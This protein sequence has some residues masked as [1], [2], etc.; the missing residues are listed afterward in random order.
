MKKIVFLT[1]AF[2]LIFNVV[3]N[4]PDV[5]ASN[6]SEY[7]DVEIDGENVRSRKIDI[8]FN[9]QALESDVPP[10]LY[11]SRTL[12][13][14]RFIAEKL[15]AEIEWIQETKE[16]KIKALGK[17]IVLKIDSSDVIINGQ[18]KKLPYD[19]P[20]KLVNNARTMIP[21]RFVM[22][23]LGCDIYWNPE[24][25][26][27]EI[28]I[29][30]QEIV[31]IIIDDSTYLPRITVE[32]T[33]VVVYNAVEIKELNK[34]VI[35]IPCSKLNIKDEEKIDSRML[36]NMDVDKFPVQRIRASQFQID[37]Y[38]TRVVLD[39]DNI[40]DYKIKY[41]DEGNGFE[42]VFINRITDISLEND[43]DEEKIV[44]H[45]SGKAKYSTFILENPNRIVVDL[46]SSYY[47]GDKYKYNL[48][49]DFVDAVRIAQFEPSGDYNKNENIVRI[50]LDI[51]DTAYIPNLVTKN[52]DGNLALYLKENN[53]RS[54][55]YKNEDIEKASLSINTLEKADCEVSY[56][57]NIKSM[58]IRFNKDKINLSN[59]MLS[60][61]DDIVSN[62]TIKED[63][64]DKI[65][66]LQFRL[67]VIYDIEA[68]EE[69]NQFNISIESKR[70]KHLKKLIII[71][72]GHGGKDPGTT[73]VTSKVK[74][75]DLNL[76]V[77]KKLDEKLR[78]NGFET[79][80]I[81][82]EDM[83]IGL[84]ERAEIANKSDG[85][86]FISIHFNANTNPDIS[87]IET[88]YC[89]SYESEVKNEDNYPFAKTLHDELL[90][91][92]ER[93]DRGIKRKPQIVVTR[94]TKMVAALLELGYLSNLEEE[95]MIV[96]HDYIDKAIEAITNGLIK[97]FE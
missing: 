50:V 57:E 89:P 6:D 2:L 13:P 95:E 5:F 35:D 76:L 83:Y 32:T 16:A 12:V 74:E 69:K 96:N 65:I 23:E 14:I 94:E 27:A 51:K 7:V 78:E 71:D 8:L 72:A 29:R 93:E 31:D 61:N 10:I 49:T 55:D 81:R 43:N 80:L 28:N 87:G 33:G 45:N 17:E 41:L 21:L 60:I 1:F 68:N 77:A 86:A 4:N 9:G 70:R 79:L 67:D 11:E 3:L 20:A 53:L 97:Y 88:I 66:M 42:I 15:N 22:E 75:K 92:L 90:K 52:E 26:T 46:M 56:N 54:I 39:L 37:P 24:T 47:E 30:E 36:V 58:E 84:Y 38:V 40:T 34:L 64:E 85:D 62:I 25:W 63:K 82:S 18:K 48:E 91:K 44:I 73:G 59:G 19:V